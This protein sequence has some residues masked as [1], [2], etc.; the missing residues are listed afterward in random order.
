VGV[1]GSYSVSKA[2]VSGGGVYLEPGDYVLEVEA[3]KGIQTRGKGP[4][5][6]ADFIV[7]ESSNEKFPAGSRVNHTILM[8]K[9][10][11]P[12]N[13]KEILAA[14]S[15]LDAASSADAAAVNAEDW[16]AV[17]ENCVV[18]PLFAGK[19]I[20]ARAVSKTKKDGS[21]AYTRTFFAPHA[22]TREAL[23]GKPKSK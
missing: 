23:H 4:M 18:K 15:G 1:F 5:F 11:G 17:L 16:D 13:A 21:G 3:T 9:D 22:S 6:V 14:L 20:K 2:K 10:Y 7:R 8:D 19:L 12:G